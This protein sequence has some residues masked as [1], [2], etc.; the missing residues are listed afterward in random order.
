MLKGSGFH[1]ED[2][3]YGKEENGE[4]YEGLHKMMMIC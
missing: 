4:D 1:C 3:G 2:L